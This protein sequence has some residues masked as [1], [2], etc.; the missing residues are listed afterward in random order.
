VDL[1]TGWIE[2]LAVHHRSQQA[3]FEAIQTMRTRLPFLL[4]GLDSDKA[5]NLLTICSTNTAFPKRSL[6]PAHALTRRTIRPMS[7]RKTGPSSV[8]SSGMTASKPKTNTCS[9]KASTQTC[10]YMPTSS[11]LS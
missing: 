3:V 9:Y 5:A 8:A 11:S 4:L 6:S 10:A 1:S 7:S 2:C